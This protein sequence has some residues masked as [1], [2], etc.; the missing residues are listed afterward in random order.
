MSSMSEA[1]IES[2]YERLALG[3]DAAGEENAHVF[4]A[5]VAL[6]LANEVGDSER[7]ISLIE[8]A[9]LDLVDS[10]NNNSK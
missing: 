4:L 6:L 5:K 1:A 9:G 2:V 8:A 10:S 3:I 7:V